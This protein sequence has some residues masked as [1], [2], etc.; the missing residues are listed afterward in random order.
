M[1]LP[2]LPDVSEPSRSPAVRTRQGDWDAA[3]SGF[4]EGGGLG[5]YY[6]CKHL[7]PL[8]A[9]PYREKIVQAMG[10]IYGDELGHAAQ[11]F[12]AVV[13]IAATASDEQWQQVLEKVEAVGYH[14]VRMRNEQFGY[15][16]SEERIAEIHAGKIGPYLL[17]LPDVEEVYR[18]VITST[19]AR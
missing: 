11:G 19:E 9:D 14:R 6:I 3:V 13:R 5:I 8:E 18:E 17:P 1:A 16:L 12:R 7:K 2:G 15:P 4:H 10:M